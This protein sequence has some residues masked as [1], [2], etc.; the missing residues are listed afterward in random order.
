MQIIGKVV[1]INTSDGMA[2]LSIVDQE[3]APWN[4][5]ASLELTFQIGH[6]YIFEVEK[7]L[8]ERISYVVEKYE[9]VQNLSIE[10]NDRFLRM[11]YPSSPYSLE[12]SKK[13]I[14]DAIAQ[15]EN[16]IVLDI[17]KSLLESNE[18][19]FFIYPAASR[20]H[21]T[22][23]GGLAYHTI[24]MLKLAETFIQNYPYLKKDYLYAGI[25][26]HDLGK[27]SELTGVEAT[28]YTVDGQLLGHLVMG[29]LEISKMAD[30]L[31]YGNTS[32]VRSLEHMLISHHGQPQFG[33]AKRPMTPEAVA[34]WYID[35]IDS[36][37]RVLG[38]E[39]NKTEVN[40]FTD[41]IGVLDK[42]K[43]YKE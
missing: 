25:I 40:H 42:V 11:F 19:K 43:I 22:Y 3:N 34:L 9:A 30:R 10:E 1:A 5:K 18:K 14:Y 8:K 7:N 26:L 28:E 24:G 32:E 17:T 33:A 36:K 4:I 13:V 31:G 39:L 38:E 16:K 41:T 29:A 23:V 35:T 6:V 37:F 21:H 12:D 15:I 20:M 27:T 2:N